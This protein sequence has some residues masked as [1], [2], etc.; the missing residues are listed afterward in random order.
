MNYNTNTNIKNIDVNFNEET[1]RELLHNFCHIK[2]NNEMEFQY[3]Y[4]KQITSFIEQKQI[5][6]YL[7]FIIENILMKYETFIVHVNIEKLTLLEIEKNRAFIIDMSTVLKEK[8]SDKLDSCIIYEGSFIFKQIY[9]FL[10]IF[11]DK[12]TLKKIRFQEKNI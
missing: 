9:N 11:I 8:F 10:A 6:N 2:I 7:I 5:L 4:F 3:K 1:L 12:K